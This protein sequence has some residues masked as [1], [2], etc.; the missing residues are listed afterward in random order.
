MRNT[1]THRSKV[2]HHMAWFKN[3]FR[4]LVGEAAKQAL[5]SLAWPFVAG[6]ITV[7]LG[8]LQGVPW[9][10][11]WVATG[12]MFAAVTHGILRFSEL[13]ER[14]R[15][16][17]KIG[18]ANIGISKALDNKNSFILGVLLSN[19]ASFPIECECDDLR[20][21]LSDKIPQKR[22]PKQS[23]VIP[24]RGIGGTFDNPISIISP[25]APGVLEGLIEFKFKYGLPK[26]QLT[27]E[28]TGKKRIIAQYLLT[29]ELLTRFRG[30]M[31]ARIPVAGGN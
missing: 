1:R 30:C 11:V 4:E 15:V 10:Y 16:E 13:R 24:P 29:M 27:H 19:S 17:G 22:L 26:T 7:P 20:T 6:A 21:N 23:F 2:Q 18:C 12:V 9:M 25:P 28:C 3:L 31:L 8:L 5:S 14:Q